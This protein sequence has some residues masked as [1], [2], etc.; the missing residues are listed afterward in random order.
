MRCGYEKRILFCERLG[1]LA[2]Y[3]DGDLGLRTRLVNGSCREGVE[4]PGR[5]FHSHNKGMAF[6]PRR[7]GDFGILYTT[8]PSF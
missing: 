8:F 4:V 5:R 3:G 6:M 7:R 1:W 2:E